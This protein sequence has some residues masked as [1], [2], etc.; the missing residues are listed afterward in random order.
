ME[1]SVKSRAVDL[2][3]TWTRLHIPSSTGKLSGSALSQTNSDH[4]S[5]CRGVSST[6]A[7]S[8]VQYNRLDQGTAKIPY[9]PPSGRRSGSL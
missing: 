2:T 8:H 6:R 7:G 4:E 9:K 5:R 3:T 1:L